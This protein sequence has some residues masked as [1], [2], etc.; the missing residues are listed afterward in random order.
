MYLKAIQDME[1]AL[2]Q[3]AWIVS[4]D[5][6]L[7]DIALAPYFQTLHQFGWTQLYEE[8]YPCVTAWYARCRGWE[9]YHSMFK[10]F[11]LDICRQ[12]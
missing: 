3:H 6:S 4:D 5:F 10:F 7:A 11:L 1:A 8:H 9:S 2:S 12:L